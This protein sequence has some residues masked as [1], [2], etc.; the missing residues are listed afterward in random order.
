[1]KSVFVEIIVISCFISCATIDNDDSQQSLLKDQDII[2]LN[3]IVDID[4]RDIPDYLLSTVYGDTIRLADIVSKTEKL[5]LLVTHR[6]CQECVHKEFE[7]LKIFDEDASTI[8]I[9]MDVPN[10]R[11]VYSFIQHYNLDIQVFSMIN[12][13]LNNSLRVLNVPFYFVTDSSLRIQHPFYIPFQ[14]PNESTNL[15][16]QKAFSSINKL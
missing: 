10:P 12:D 16:L 3:S 13:S 9:L 6:C 4:N 11:E 2:I 7:R 14:K 5:F 8:N 15:Y 1:M